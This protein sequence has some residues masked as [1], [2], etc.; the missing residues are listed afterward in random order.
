MFF[1]WPHFD[2]E[3]FI[4]L[5]NA[6]IKKKAF[7]TLSFIHSFIPISTSVNWWWWWGFECWIVRHRRLYSFD[8][9]TFIIFYVFSFHLLFLPSSFTSWKT[10][11]TNNVIA[12]ISYMYDFLLYFIKLLYIVWIYLF[13]ILYVE[14]LV[15]KFLITF[16]VKQ[17]LS[18]VI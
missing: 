7:F 16:S 10:N 4:F 3:I 1:W 9:A 14:I 13:I 17:K 15:I 11:F 18:W 5:L 12:F 2:H 8:F 6:K